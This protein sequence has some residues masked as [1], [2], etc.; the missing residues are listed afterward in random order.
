[1]L[2]LPEIRCESRLRVERRYAGWRRK[3]KMGARVIPAIIGAMICLIGVLPFQTDAFASEVKSL[4]VLQG[5]ILELK[6]SGPGLTAVEG[7]LGKD[8]ILFYSGEDQKYSALIGM[9]L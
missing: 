7:S 1:M 8:K 4:E 6:V 5:G 9:D 2:S 3:N